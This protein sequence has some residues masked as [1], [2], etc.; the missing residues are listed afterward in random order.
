MAKKYTGQIGGN[1]FQEINYYAVDQ[2]VASTISQK[3][4]ATKSTQ[5]SRT[6][7]QL[8]KI[9]QTM[10]AEMFDAIGADI[11]AAGEKL[12]DE[13]VQL[14]LHMTREQVSKTEKNP[15]LA[16]GWRGRDFLLGQRLRYALLQRN[17]WFIN[18][19]HKSRITNPILNTNWCAWISFYWR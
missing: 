8:T 3:A 7:N 17:L 16:D 6:V 18:H 9:L 13:Q 19:I 11:I 14:E 10:P 5:I 4:L 12:N 15:Y 1:G 2:M